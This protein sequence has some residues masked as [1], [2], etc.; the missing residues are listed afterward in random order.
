MHLSHDRFYSWILCRGS[1]G[2]MN[3]FIYFFAALR[4]TSAFLNAN[5]MELNLTQSTQANAGNILNV[6]LFNINYMWTIFVDILFVPLYTLN[7]IEHIKF[8]FTFYTFNY[9]SYHN[10]DMC[11]LYRIVLLATPFDQV[12]W[13]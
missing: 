5:A 10:H 3:N 7:S 9:Y 12:A 8:V 6:F 11:F 13:S 1:S 4:K 2:N